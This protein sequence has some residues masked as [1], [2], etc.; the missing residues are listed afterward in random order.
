M[1]RLLLLRVPLMRCVLSHTSPI[2]FQQ[3]LGARGSYWGLDGVSPSSHV[4]ILTPSTSVEHGMERSFLVQP[5]PF[6]REETEA[7]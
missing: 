1:A 2:S 6:T 5:T 3:C 4:E 7:Q